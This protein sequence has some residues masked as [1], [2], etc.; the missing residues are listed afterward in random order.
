MIQLPLTI[1][2]GK[3]MPKSKR[4]RTP[5]QLANDERLRS[6]NK[7]PQS[8]TKE[9]SMMEGVTLTQDQYD[10]LMTRLESLESQ[11]STTVDQ[12]LKQPETVS[13][14]SMGQT[15]GVIT[16]FPIEATFYPDPREELYD[17]PEIQFRA[18][19]QNVK[20]VWNVSGQVYETK[21][22]TNVQEPFFKLDVYR[23]DRDEEGTVKP[24]SFRIARLI[25]NEDETEALKIAQEMGLN[26]NMADMRE[27]MNVARF[28][29]IKR[30][31][32]PLFLGHKIPSLQNNSTEQVDPQTGRA[33]QMTNTAEL[34]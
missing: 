30:F 19:R 7:N 8:Q 20:F 16:K 25:F 21:F 1:H 31:I 32:L 23:L 3:Q 11:P 28:E 4:Q 14:G 15:V 13:I 17:I 33:M 6:K 27:I 22:G 26:L 29:R 2:E 5:A 12:H 10:T 34:L 9:S 18:P 24:E